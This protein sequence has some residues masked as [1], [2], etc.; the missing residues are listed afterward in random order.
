MAV[1]FAW[2]VLGDVSLRVQVLEHLDPPK[3]ESCQLQLS[4]L[5]AL[6]GRSASLGSTSLHAAA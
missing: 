6:S 2:K 5:F 1:G 4:E 3:A